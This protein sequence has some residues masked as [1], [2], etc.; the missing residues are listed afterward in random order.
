MG[1]AA[2]KPTAVIVHATAIAVDGRAALLFGASGSGKSDLALRSIVTVARLGGRLVTPE[3]VADDQVEITR[4]GG[5]LVCR[6][7]TTLAGR[8]E[9]R[10]LGIVDVPHV[11]VARVALAVII[12]GPPAERMP[13]PATRQIL[14]MEVPEIRLSPFEASA[15]MKLLLALQQAP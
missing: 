10:G 5:H 14:G 2:D 6:P 11:T 7:P 15:P 1:G 12:D 4:D 13:A 3:L 8:I 9:V